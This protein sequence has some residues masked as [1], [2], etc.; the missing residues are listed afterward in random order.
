[1]GEIKIGDKV[2]V[3]YVGTFKDG[4]EFD[5]S[6]KRETPL[7]LVIGEGKVLLEF[8]NTI[9]TM[10]VGDKKKVHIPCEKAYGEVIK[11]AITKAPRNEFPEDFRF[12]I[13]ERIKG[14]TK[15]G[16]PATA[17]ILEVTRTE[18]TLDMNHP[19]AGKDLN[20]EIELLE[21]EK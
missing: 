6:V 1:M 4:T 12:I 16:K 9:R 11:E 18:V 21:I 13:D 20:F 8:E 2:K 7:D 5:S 15:S 10:S 17:V 3:H 19:L 14:D